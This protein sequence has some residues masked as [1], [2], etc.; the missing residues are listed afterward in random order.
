M[1]IL[2]N[3]I[4]YYNPDINSRYNLKAEKYSPDYFYFH[5]KKWACRLLWKFFQSHANS[6]F[7]ESN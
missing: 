6:I 4:E 2:R 3:V 5:S 1:D 7:H